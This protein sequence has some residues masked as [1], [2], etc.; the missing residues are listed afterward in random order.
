MYCPKCKSEYLEGVYVCPDCNI[1]LVD[2][3]SAEEKPS[4]EYLDLV[5]VFETGDQSKLLVAKSILDE[6]GI[7]YYIRGENIQDLF[8]LGRIGSGYNM[9]LGPV[10]IQVLRSSE[11]EAK[12]LL[13]ELSKN[14]EDDAV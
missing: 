4:P 2:E 7:E 1:S 9:I 3:L 6:V 12:S 13:S 14:K 8:G 10:Q 11:N 5:T